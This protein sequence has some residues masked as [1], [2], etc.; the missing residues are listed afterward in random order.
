M[1]GVW[2]TIFCI[3]FYFVEDFIYLT[4]LFDN[5]LVSLFV[6]FYYL[7]IIIIIQYYELLDFFDHLKMEG[8]Q[9]NEDLMDKENITP[10][11]DDSDCNFDLDIDD[12]DTISGVDESSSVF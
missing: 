12:L 11:S 1:L 7:F 6:L 5:Y 2:W 3:R 10:E 4:N 9:L 8:E